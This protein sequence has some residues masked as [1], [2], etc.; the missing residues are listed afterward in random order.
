VVVVATPFQLIVAPLT[1]LEPFAV[2]V[3]LDPPAVVEVGEMEVRIGIG[4]EALVIV[5]VILF[6]VPGLITVTEAVPAVTRFAVGIVAISDDP[7]P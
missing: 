1:K 4:L 5:K 3:K 2:S 6:D 7:D